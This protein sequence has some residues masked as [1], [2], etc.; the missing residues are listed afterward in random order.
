MKK[1]N[2]LVV[3]LSLYMVGCSSSGRGNYYQPNV[4][5]NSEFEEY[6]EQR[7]CLCGLSVYVMIKIL[8]KAW[9]GWSYG[10]E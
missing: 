10:T 3:L 7:L 1:R 9:K 2:I 6:T 5:G 4:Y 8:K